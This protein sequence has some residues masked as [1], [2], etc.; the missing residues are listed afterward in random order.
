MNPRAIGKAVF[1]VAFFA[2]AGYYAMSEG[3]KEGRLMA[4]CV[5]D[6]H[7][8]LTEYVTD[9]DLAERIA[10]DSCSKHNS[11]GVVKAPRS[12]Q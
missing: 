8:S 7:R 10:I 6:R 4:E 5:A 1:F 2:M 12:A 11:D 9:K 3:G